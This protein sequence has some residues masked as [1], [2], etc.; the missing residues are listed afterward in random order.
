MGVGHRHG[1]LRRAL[2]DVAVTVIVVGEESAE[3]DAGEIAVP[4]GENAERRL[5]APSAGG[6]AP[7]QDAR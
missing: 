3:G 2:V 4:L 7:A 5:L 6:S 1:E